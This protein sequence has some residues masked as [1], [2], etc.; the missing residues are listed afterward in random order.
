[1]TLGDP[2]GIGP[3]VVAKLLA[4]AG[5]QAQAEIFVIADREEFRRGAEIANVSVPH[6]EAESFED[7]N[8]ALGLPVVSPC[9]GTVTGPFPRGRA[10]REG[11]QYCLETLQV[12]VALA[13]TGRIDA[14]CHAPLNKTSLHMAGMDQ[15]DELRWFAAQFGCR[16]VISSFTVLDTLWT[17]RVTSHV[18]LK[19]VSGLLTPERVAG[20]IELIHATLRLTGLA[21]PRIAVCG[22]NPHNGEDGA[23]G[24]EEIDVIAPGIDLAR[25]HGVPADG[26]FPADTIFLKARDKRCDAIVTMYHDQGQIAMKLMGFEHAVSVHGGLPLPVTTPAHGTAFDIAGRGIANAGAMRSAF[27]LACTMGRLHRSSHS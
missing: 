26:P 18:A 15:P 27:A 13:R 4:E 19:D 9:R 10:S 1:M 21:A 23:F 17:S 2:A 16:G 22:L 5:P 12:G 25:Q 7:A 6:V 3:E 8:L 14:L 20:A 24:R 11:G